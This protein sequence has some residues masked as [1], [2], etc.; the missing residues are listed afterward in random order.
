VLVAEDTPT[1]QVVI[2]LMLERLGHSVVVVNDG[3][4]AVRA[5]SREPFDLVF[6]DLQMPVMDG[7]EAA[8]AI[9][10][11]S[12]ARGPGVRPVPIV[13]LSAFSQPSDRQKALERGMAAYLDKP[14]KSADVARLIASLKG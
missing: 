12:C 2:R 7:Y 3:A 5:F 4:E 13:A 11:A 6:L 1:N 9:R 8:G 10:A 14:I